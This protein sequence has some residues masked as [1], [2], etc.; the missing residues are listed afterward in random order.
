MCFAAVIEGPSSTRQRG[1]DDRLLMRSAE[2]GFPYA[3][4]LLA[5]RSLTIPDEVSKEQAF[6]LASRAAAQDERDGIL[7]LGMFYNVGR[8]VAR[9]TEYGMSEDHMLFVVVVLTLSTK[10]FDEESSFNGL[11][12]CTD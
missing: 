6:D 9:N 5:R 4:A 12:R 3:Q 7:L 1:G 11:N 8:G 2:L 10:R